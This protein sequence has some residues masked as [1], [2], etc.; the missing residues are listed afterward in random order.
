MV[1]QAKFCVRDSHRQA[2][3]SE[4]YGNG[5]TLA[6][7]QHRV[8]PFVQAEEIGK[9]GEYFA[10]V[11]LVELFAHIRISAVQQFRYIVVGN[12]SLSGTTS[13][14]NCST[15]LAISSLRR[16]P[17]CLVLEIA[18]GGAVALAAP[19]RRSNAASNSST[20]VLRS[21]FKILNGRGLYSRAGMCPI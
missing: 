6:F 21:G 13:P 11:F 19:S 7:A 4:C 5:S 14:S 10:S 1:E 2:T 12:R 20:N 9:F 18:C 17:R 16:P 3:Q 8:C 15:N